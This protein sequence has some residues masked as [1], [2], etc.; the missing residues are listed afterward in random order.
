MALYKF[1]YLLMSDCVNITRA[2]SDV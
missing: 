2:S 1:T